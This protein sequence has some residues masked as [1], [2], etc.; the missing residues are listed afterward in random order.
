MFWL[1]TP[2]QC[3]MK[4]EL[5]WCQLSHMYD[6]CP[7]IALILKHQIP[8]QLKIANIRLISLWITKLFQLEFTI[9][10]WNT[11]ISLSI[12]IDRAAY[13]VLYCFSS[14]VQEP[15]ILIMIFSKLFI[16][17]IGCHITSFLQLVNAKWR[18][19]FLSFQIN[20][21]LGAYWR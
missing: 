8:C 3:I 7:L 20:R 15:D 5:A 14:N 6:I 9:S 10:P 13:I 16:K 1:I 2:Q 18:L 11:K 17:I 21:D 12:I 4:H 19:P